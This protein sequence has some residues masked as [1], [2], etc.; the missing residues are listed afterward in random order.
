[1]VPLLTVVV[2]DAPLSWD[3]PLPEAEANTSSGADLSSP[4]YSIAS[5]TENDVVFPE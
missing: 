2:G 4:E 5:T 1:M 3:V